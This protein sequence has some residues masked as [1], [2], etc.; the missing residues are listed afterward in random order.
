MN[1]IDPRLSVVVASLNG[2]G[3]LADCIT[4][5][6]RQPRG[7]E[8]EVVVAESSDNDMAA[9]ICSQYANVRLFHFAER[10]SIPELRATGLLNARGEI[11]A[12]TE[13]HCLAD[14]HWVE[15]ILHAH[16]SP[17]LVIG[18][19]VENAA[20]ER[21]ID[22][23]VYFCEYGRYMLPVAAGP[24][25][26]LPGPNVSYKRMALDYFRDLLAPASWEPFW[27][28]RLVSRGITLINDP[29]LVVYHCKNFTLRGFLDERYYYARSFAGRRVEGAPRHK[30]ALFI[31]A[32]PLLPPLLLGRIVGRVLRKGRHRRELFLSLPYI[33]LFTLSWSL[34][35]LIGY[36]WGA[37]DSLDKIE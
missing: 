24:T 14:A 17:S 4:S 20:T 2:A 37:G 6:V 15:N 28:W 7:N 12:M 19:A 36:A 9:K 13:D 10:R 31:L 29:S 21:L 23:A 26:D 16:E 34:G 27:H 3:S 30:R 8:I 32:A 1:P 35:E 33:I 22:W 25:V 5:F 18:G 11:L